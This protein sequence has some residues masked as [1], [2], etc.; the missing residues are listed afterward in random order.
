MFKTRNLVFIAILGSL[1][2]LLMLINFP[3]LPGAD[4]LKVD[5]S[6]LPI[7]VAMTLFGEKSAYMV[8]MIRS[9]LKLLLDTASI[10]HLIGLPMNIVAMA[11]FVWVF[12]R[13]W[14][15][16]KTWS[17]FLVTGVLATLAMTV[18]MLPLN[19][20]YAIPIYAQFAHFDIS[21]MIG[22]KTYFCS[23]VIPF[24]LLQGSLLSLSFGLLLVPM[25]P[26]IERYRPHL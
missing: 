15:T 17:S 5:F 9:V 4:F 14:H 7:L 20:C 6:I 2:F 19:Y 11:V 23:M 10:A 8:L 1:S 16:G 22:L 18:I 13:L 24:N 26:L 12:A 3:I 25:T 21:Q